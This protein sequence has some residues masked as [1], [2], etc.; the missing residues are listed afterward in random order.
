M[1]M[2][3]DWWIELESTYKH[4]INQRKLLH[5][6]H[7]RAILDF[8]PGSEAACQELMFMVIQFLCARYPQLFTLSNAKSSP[9]VFQNRILQ[10]HVN[11]S[12]AARD[13]LRF[14]LDNVPEDFLIT[15]KDL[16][17]GL[18][19]LRGGVACSAIGWN[20]GTKIGKPLHEIHQ[21]VPEFAG[22][23]QS[24]VEK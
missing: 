8:M 22:V 5:A 3:P 17:T 13:P 1:P 16:G 18:Y 7:G 23:L 24:S 19:H 2:E 21:P 12:D 4:R 11:I 6:Q 15:Q 14:L 10:T 20:L 9:T